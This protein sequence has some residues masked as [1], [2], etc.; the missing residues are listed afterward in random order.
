MKRRQGS[1]WCAWRVGTWGPRLPPWSPRRGSCRLRLCMLLQVASVIWEAE[2]VVGTRGCHTECGVQAERSEDGEDTKDSGASQGPRISRPAVLSH[3]DP[4]KYKINK[5]RRRLLKPQ[6]GTVFP[7]RC[8]SS[9]VNSFCSFLSLLIASEG[10]IH[11]VFSCMSVPRW[12]SVGIIDSNSDCG[13]ITVA[14]KF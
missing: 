3:K 1:L 9:S 14:K 5:K 7:T 10:A 6:V 4:K 12:V 13:F 2:M 11:S 8:F